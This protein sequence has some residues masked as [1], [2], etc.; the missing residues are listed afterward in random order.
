METTTKRKESNTEN[1]LKNN[2]FEFYLDTSNEC[3][4]FDM[5]RDR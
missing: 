4:H 2:T 1:L 5:V 3:R